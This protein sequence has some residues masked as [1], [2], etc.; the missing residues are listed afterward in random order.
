MK[1]DN[2]KRKMSFF[3]ILKSIS[4]KLQLFFTS[5]ALQCFLL[6]CCSKLMSYSQLV[7]KHFLFSFFF[8]SKSFVSVHVALHVI[9]LCSFSFALSSMFKV[10]EQFKYFWSSYGHYAGYQGNLLKNWQSVGH[11]FLCALIFICTCAPRYH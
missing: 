1:K 7:V 11:C 10:Q 4:N 8:S 2:P 6:F 3:F 5:S 9:I